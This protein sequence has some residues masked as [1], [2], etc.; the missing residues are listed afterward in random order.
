MKTRASWSVDPTQ[1]GPDAIEQLSK[2]ARFGE[3][4]ICASVQRGDLVGFRSMNRE[5]D[6]RC[7]NQ[8]AET[9]GNFDSIDIR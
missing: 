9:T 5:D 8:E 6:D 2:I 3:V 4:V 7:L 1:S